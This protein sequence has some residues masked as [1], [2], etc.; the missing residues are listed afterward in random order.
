MFLT[1]IL[2]KSSVTLSPVKWRHEPHRSYRTTVQ[3]VKPLIGVL[4]FCSD[5]P[6]K[7]WNCDYIYK[8]EL[9][10]SKCKVLQNLPQNLN[11]FEIIGIKKDYNVTNEEIHRKY[12]ELQKMLH[13]DKF[14][15]KSEASIFVKRKR[16][17]SLV[18]SSLFI[19]NIIS[20]I[21]A[22]ISNLFFTANRKKDKSQRI[23]HL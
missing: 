6:P 18:P 22:Y 17:T 13:P 7:C 3:P 16:N 5:G 8:S 9:F 19:Y 11:Y 21:Y 14:G 12:R 2:R 23:Y 20:T 1:R 4:R 15:N 10:C